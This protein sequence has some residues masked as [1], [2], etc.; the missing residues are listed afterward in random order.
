MPG[1][2]MVRIG[3]KCISIGCDNANT[4]WFAG[5]F[6]DVFVF[7]A[8]RLTGCGLAIRPGWSAGLLLFFSF[9]CPR[10]KGAEKRKKRRYRGTNRERSGL[11]CVAT[12]AVTFL[13]IVAI[14]AIGEAAFW[15]LD[16]ILHC[17]N[18]DCV[19]AFR[20]A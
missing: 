16:A 4:V 20:T 14:V 3:F 12:A 11:I 13:C 10:K 15:A 2:V 5:P 18:V 7:H 19:A 1:A 17:G 6:L 9:F 8:G